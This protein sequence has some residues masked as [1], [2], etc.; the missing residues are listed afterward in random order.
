MTITRNHLRA[1]LAVAAAL[2]L[3]LPAVSAEEEQAAPAAAAPAPATPADA[4]AAAPDKT[5]KAPTPVKRAPLIQVALLLDTSNSMDGL[6][7]Q[8][9]T[10][11]WRIVNE[12]ARATREGAR[13]ELKVALYEYGNDGLKVETGYVRQVAA[14][15][16]DLDKVS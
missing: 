3:A 8:A 4:P 9:K 6:I 7:A 13:P 15:T 16:D 14:L 11:L 2:A 10:H 1:A 5:T 12:F